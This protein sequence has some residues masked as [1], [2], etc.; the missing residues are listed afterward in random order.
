MSN[1]TFQMEEQLSDLRSSEIAYR[2][3]AE[4]RGAKPIHLRSLTPRVPEGVTLLEVKDTSERAVRLRHE[5]LCAELTAT[6]KAYLIR[7]ERA[8]RPK[9]SILSFVS[10]TTA[11]SPPSVIRDLAST[12]TSGVVR[13]IDFVV[14]G[15]NDAE[16][17]LKTWFSV[18]S[19]SEEIPERKLFEAK[20]T[21]LKRYEEQVETERKE[22]PSRLE[23]ATLASGSVFATTFVFS[24]ARDLV[25]PRKYTVAV[26]TSFQENG[27]DIVEAGAVSA[28]TII[29]PRPL[30]LS[31][32]AMLSSVLGGVLKAAL[33]TGKVV[34]STALGVTPPG[35][36]PFDLVVQYLQSPV[37]LDTLAGMVAALVVFN[38]YEHTEFGARVKMGVGWR[39]ALVIGVLAGLL[40]ERFIAALVAFIGAPT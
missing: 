11:S 27:S 32:I 28:S 31:C 36:T 9:S 15:V 2:F 24:F 13:T 5:T 4:N 37:V 39:S 14:H 34:T 17:A 20:L 7:L 38:I 29:S 19:G 12:D 33:K 23:I 22:A 3:T 1:V 40:T 16:T 30:L 18:S 35:D 21:Q 6:L 25:E 10:S 26:E 8:R